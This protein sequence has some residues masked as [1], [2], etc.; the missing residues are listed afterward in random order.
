MIAATLL[1]KR[2]FPR[3]LEYDVL[4]VRQYFTDKRTI[5]FT[6]AIVIMDLGIYIPWVSNGNIYFIFR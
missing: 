2:R 3:T 1:V 6:I 4:P 5:M